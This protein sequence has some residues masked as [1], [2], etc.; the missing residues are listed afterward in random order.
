MIAYSV[1]VLSIWTPLALEV[2]TTF[3]FGEGNAKWLETVFGVT[4]VTSIQKQS[5]VS[6]E[7]SWFLAKT[8][9]RILPC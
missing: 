7:A 1:T 2:L 9:E 3:P 6:S 8:S 5:V 4:T